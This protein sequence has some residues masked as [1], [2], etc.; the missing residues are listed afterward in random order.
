LLNSD[1]QSKA[2]KFED[3]HIDIGANSREEAEKLVSL[4]DLVVYDDDMREFGDGFIKTKAIDDR[5]G[6]SVMIKLIESDLP[7]DC[8]FAFTVQEEVGLRGSYPAAFRVEPE[9]AIVIEGT[10]AADLPSVTDV[11]K[12]CKARGG[13]VIPFMDAG[14]IYNR[15]LFGIFTK[16]AEKN[17]IPWQTK[18]VV[19]GAT[20]AA[21]IQRSR[22]GVKTLGIAAPVRNLHSQSCV[23]KISDMDYVYE[24]ARLSINELAVC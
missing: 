8:S 15:E 2:I 18:T 21:A 4:G 17:N 9:I 11:R 23:V 16:L 14:T 20:D 24:L 13:V 19:A 10:T 6:C 5:V 22:S 12:I 1:E 7:Y 3:M